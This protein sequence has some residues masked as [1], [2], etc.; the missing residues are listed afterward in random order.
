MIRKVFFLDIDDCLIHTSALTDKHLYAIK[1]EL[2]KFG[3]KKAREITQEFAA[4]FQ[5][6][7]DVHQGKHLSSYNQKLFEDYLRKLTQLEKPVVEKFGEIKR[8]SREICLFIAGQ[9]YSIDLSN[10]ILVKTANTLWTKI[11]QYANFYPD[12]EIFLNKL[13]HQHIPFFLITSSDSRLTKDDKTSLFY[14]D[15]KYSRDLKMNRL[16]KFIDLGIPSEHIFIG[17]PVDKP[18]LWVFEE[19]L[20]YARNELQ[21]DFESVMISDSYSNDLIQAEKVGMD[22]FVLILRHN[23]QTKLFPKKFKLITI[24]KLN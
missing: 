10:E 21:T 20:K 9:K 15:P 11:T 22:K 24:R 23:S 16:Q 3:I 14:Y 1:E 19:A 2:N 6:L 4:S 18:K 12:A 5:R 17:D 8:C 7:Y 13:I